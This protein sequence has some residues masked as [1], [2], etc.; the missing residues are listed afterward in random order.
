[1]VTNVYSFAQNND[2]YKRVFIRTK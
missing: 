1:M 2:G